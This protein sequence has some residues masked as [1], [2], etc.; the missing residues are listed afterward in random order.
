VDISLAK[1]ET[2]IGGESKTVTKQFALLRADYVIMHVLNLD[3]D[4]FAD[5]FYEGRI[6]LNKLLLAKKSTRLSRGDCI[7]ILQP[8]TESTP[9]GVTVVKRI[10]L[11]DV[12]RVAANKV[13]CEMEYWKPGIRIKQEET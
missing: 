8:E 4:G 13:K 5:I 11:T 1:N 2:S 6:T 3:R 9:K 10:M 7:D 12:Q